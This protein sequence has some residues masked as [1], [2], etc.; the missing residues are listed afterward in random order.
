MLTRAKLLNHL[1]YEIPCIWSIKL[2]R[3]YSLALEA[4]LLVKKK[5]ELLLSNITQYSFQLVF[6]FTIILARF[7]AAWDVRAAAYHKPSTMVGIL[8]PFPNIINFFVATQTIFCLIHW[9]LLC[10]KKPNNSLHYLLSTALQC[11]GSPCLKS[12]YIS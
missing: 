8:F 1:C 11:T 6:F 7:H 9:P 12:H 10:W 5:R 3:F 4:L 2:Y